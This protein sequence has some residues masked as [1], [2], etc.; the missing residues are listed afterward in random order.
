[1]TITVVVRIAVSVGGIGHAAA[2]QTPPSYCS[3]VY[4][5]P[6]RTPYPGP[7]PAAIEIFVFESR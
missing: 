2:V 3:L 4:S 1:M 5:F 7:Q 6:T